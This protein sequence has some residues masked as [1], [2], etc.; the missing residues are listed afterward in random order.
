VSR[1]LALPFPHRPGFSRG[2]FIPAGSNAAARGWLARTADWPDRRLALWGEAGRGKTHLLRVWAER[3][4]AALL[5]AAALRS[6]PALPQA[7]VALDD[8]DLCPE[9]PALLHL[10]NAA[11]EAGVLVLLAG[12]TPPARWPVKLADLRSR[13]RAVA[14][15]EIGPP[16]D[17]LLRALLASLLAE[18]QLAVAP[19]VQDWLLARLP[20]SAAALREAAARLDRASLAAGR[21]VGR[22]LAASVLADLDPSGE[23][24]PAGRTAGSSCEPGFL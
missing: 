17:G 22:L 16:E 23:A 5:D 15:V 12:R 11:G 3:H 8:A 21:P 24:E 13:L 19:E 6:L 18:R 20:R 1:Q 10:L 14:T 2:S 9:A 7:P 4:G